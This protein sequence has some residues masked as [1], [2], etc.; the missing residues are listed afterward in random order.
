MDRAEKIVGGDFI[1]WDEKVRLFTTVISCDGEQGRLCAIKEFSRIC[2]LAPDSALFGMVPVLVE[3]FRSSPPAIRDSTAFALC[4]LARRAGA[5]FCATIGQLG[6][7]PI[8]LGLYRSRDVL[9]RSLLRLLS[10]LV[11]VDGANRVTLARNGG[12]D[13]VLDL[14]SSCTDDTKKYLLEI[15][16][17]LAMLR[18][19]R[20]VA[21]RLGIFP[22][23]IEAL[24]ACRMIS[25]MQAAHAI[26]L[27]G[28]ARR[29]RH[30]L[31][32]LGA[33][34]AL[35]QLIREGDRSVKLI[36]SNALG[37]ISSHVDCIRPVA[38]AG[39]IPLYIELLES[40]EPLGREIAE[41]VLCILAVDEENATAISEQLVRILRGSDEDAMSAAVDV[42]WD[43]A[44]Y[45]HS[46]S[47]M[48]DSGAI[49]LLM[50][51][52]LNGSVDIREKVM[53]TIAQ[54]SYDAAN[55]RALVEAG[56]IPLLI[57]L[58]RGDSEELR[59]YAVESLI[60]F[61]EDPV[62]RDFVVEAFDIPSFVDA[63][64]RIN[65]IRASDEYMSRSMRLLSIEQLTSDTEL[66]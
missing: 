16:S 48:R 47:V 46:A 2:K 9:R 20:R 59:D 25:R 38:E 3:L 15:L 18:G 43:L 27:L 31:V 40:S 51:V 7:I 11:A 56:G 30:M 50:E 44:G 6:T 5:P 66:S 57:G 29:V 24:S 54:L 8:I 10:A 28:V 55:R 17:A 23:L 1:D 36:A 4:R 34:P 45:K 33:V 21:V 14:I 65:R 64:D 49:P 19:V 35:V 42:L 26:G 37:I 63:R 52:L 61:E 32:E 12:L 60:N 22:F 39:A 41:D 62:L 58:L 13:I 53:G